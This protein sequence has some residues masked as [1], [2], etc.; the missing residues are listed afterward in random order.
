VTDRQ[1]DRHCSRGYVVLLCIK[2]R[3]SNCSVVDVS[4]QLQKLLDVGNQRLQE[5][6]RFNED[7]YKAVMWLRGH[8]NCFKK[9][10]HEPMVLTVSVVCSARIFRY[11]WTQIPS[12][13]V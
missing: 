1:T 2:M 5:L 13:K 8:H 7:A 6:R 11:L 9:V 12:S 3:W 4:I 10:I